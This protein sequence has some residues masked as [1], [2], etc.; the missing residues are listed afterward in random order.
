VQRCVSR[1]AEVDSIITGSR[2]LPAVCCASSETQTA[3]YATHSARAALRF[4]SHAP[5][6]FW[7]WRGSISL[8]CRGCHTIISVPAALRRSTLHAPRSIWLHPLHHYHH[9][10]TPNHHR[11]PANASPARLYLLAQANWLCSNVKA[12][13]AEAGRPSSSAA[14]ARTRGERHHCDH[15]AA[16][17]Q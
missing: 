8:S 5:P 3:F 12:L 9:H 13:P 6:R 17:V 7:C 1:E 10:H 4:V 2:H 11:P 16:A 15:V 14:P